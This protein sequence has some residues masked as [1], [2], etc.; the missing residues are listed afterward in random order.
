M[1]T[2]QSHQTTI[3]TGGLFKKAGPKRSLP[4]RKLFISSFVCLIL[5]TLSAAGIRK[6]KA[7]NS[8]NKSESN[9]IVQAAPGTRCTRLSYP[10]KGEEPF[11]G[12]RCTRAFSKPGKP[13]SVLPNTPPTVELKAS[14]DNIVLRCE[15]GTA[16]TCTPDACKLAILSANASDADRD[17]VLYTFTTT[18]GRIMGDGSAVIW[19]LGSVQPGSYTASVE[20]D[21]GCG[22]IA[23]SSTTVSVGP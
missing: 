19:D 16:E 21:D 7:D 8:P 10:K 15:P 13:G 3:L 22:C 2:W 14:K 9:T 4:L 5:V 11:F 23:F 17:Q 18:G 1:K 20:V 6:S 12:T